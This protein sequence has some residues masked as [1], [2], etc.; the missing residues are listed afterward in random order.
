MDR[1][2][3]HDTLFA[4]V[5]GVVLGVTI[6]SLSQRGG[7]ETP[8]SPLQ[9]TPSATEQ[10]IERGELSNAPARFWSTDSTQGKEAQ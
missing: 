1:Q 7:I 8:V 5:V 2:R 4:I 6:W 9:K 3:L 10:M